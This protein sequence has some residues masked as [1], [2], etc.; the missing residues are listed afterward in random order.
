MNFNNKIKWIIIQFLLI[1]N[2]KQC[3]SQSLRMLVAPGNVT[4]KLDESVTLNC[5]FN[6]PVTCSWSKNLKTIKIPSD[7][8]S[9]VN[10]IS[11]GAESDDCSIIIHK[12]S[13]LD[14]TQR[15]CGAYDEV[16]VADAYVTRQ[17]PEVEETSTGLI[18]GIV[19]ACVLVFTIIVLAVV[20]I[21]RKQKQNLPQNGAVA[22][23]CDGYE[24]FKRAVPTVN[25]RE[26]NVM[27]SPELYIDVM[28]VDPYANH[29]Y[30]YITYNR[31]DPV[32]PQYLELVE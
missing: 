14:F 15:R 22:T 26:E 16:I 18:I 6:K 23:D 2:T 3:L 31:D 29:V 8:Y 11:F 28:N 25:R 9:Y 20:Y 12:L 24:I 10:G 4:G 30:T 13:D 27:T 21:K 5:K 32:E 1:I 7:T 17:V 19:V